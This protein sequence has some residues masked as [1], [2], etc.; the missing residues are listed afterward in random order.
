ME[1][2]K[3]FVSEQKLIVDGQMFTEKKEYEVWSRPGSQD[4]LVC[5]LDSRQIGNEKFQISRT[6]WFDTDGDDFEIEEKEETNLETEEE[7]KA[8]E[9]AWESGWQPFLIQAAL[10]SDG[11]FASLKKSLK[12][13]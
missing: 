11:L 8:F 2:Q 5:V 1:L 9:T 4:L 10:P 7:V 3:T 6:V 13:W 12:F